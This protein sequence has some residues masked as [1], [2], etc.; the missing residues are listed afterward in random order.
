M[1]KII[2]TLIVIFYFTAPMVNAIEEVNTVE[3]PK[4]EEYVPKKYQNPRTD[5]SRG[6]SIAELTVGI[7]LTDLLFTAPIG[8]PMICH[9]T[10]KLK[11]IGYANKKVKFENGLQ[12]AEK[13]SNPD[14]KQLYYENLL[15]KCKFTEKK[16]QKQL[17]KMSKNKNEK[18]K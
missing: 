6:A 1:K 14:E 2:A 17:K 18:L 4:W 10:T 12:E 9:A 7:V 5:F 3:A 8:I 11:N 16:R 13:I 15:K